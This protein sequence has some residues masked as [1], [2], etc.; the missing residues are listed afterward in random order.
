MGFSTGSSS[1]LAK[2]ENRV[3][4]LQY[5]QSTFGTTKQ[6][7]Y[8]TN[9]ICGN[10]IDNTDFTAIPHI[11]KT[12]TGGKGG[13]GGQTSVSYTYKSRCLIGLCCGQI[14]GV[15][16]VEFDDGIYSLSQL[17]MTLF[18]GSAAQ[19]AWGE[20]LSLH[21]EHSLTY[22]NLA[23]VAGYIDLT[24]SGGVPQ[25][26]FEVAGKC[27]F[28]GL[29]ANP[30]DVAI[31]VLTNKIYG[32]GFPSEYI[33]YSSFEEFSNYCIAN[34]VLLSPVYDA[35]EEVQSLLSDLFSICNST[36]IWTQGKLK[37]IPLCDEKITGHG[38][39]YNP[40]LTPVYDFDEKDFI[41]DDEPVKC[42]R[43]EQND[44]YN[45]VKIEY[46]NRANEY[47][48]EVVEAQDLAN[49][50][51]FGVRAADTQKAHLICRTDI[52]QSVAQLALDRNIAVRNTYTFK[53]PF[54][55]IMLD[56]MDI[57]TIT[58]PL[59]GL[60]REPVRI[61][62]IK[63]SDMQLEIEA[64][65]MVI[66]S[67]N[68]AK[69]DTQEASFVS[70]DS[71]QS[72]GNINPIMIFEPPMQLTHNT[73]EVWV[74]IS[75]NKNLFG[76]CEIYISDD[77]STYRL[78]GKQ[79]QQC[80]QGILKNHLG[81]S[82]KNPDDTN[83][84]VVDMNMSNAELL[85][86]TKEDAE[87]LNTLCYVGGEFLA[88]KAATLEDIGIYNL[89]YLNRGAYGSEVNPHY[90]GDQFTRIDED[91]F[92]KIS[93]NKEDIGKEIFIK[94]PS[95]NSFGAGIQTLGD[96]NP[97]TY[98]IQGAALK[99]APEN[100]T[101]LTNYYSDGLNII[102][103]QP[104][105][106]ARNIVYEIRKGS[107]W[108]KA[109]CLG[110]IAQTTF[111]A[112]GNGTYWVKAYVPDYNIYSVEA[113]SLEITGA[114]LVQNV[115]D[116]TDEQEKGFKGNKSKSMFV[117]DY[118]TL[119]LA[120]AGKF[121]EIEQF[122]KISSVLFFGGITQEGIYECAKVVDIGA[123]SKCYIHVEYNFL[124]ENPFSTFG[125][126]PKLSEVEK[127]IENFGEFITKSRI[128]IAIAQN[129]EF[130]DWQDFV[131]GQYFGRKF[132]FRALLESSSD[133]VVAKLNKL[134]LNIDVPDL[135][136]TGN[137]IQI[138]SDGIRIL[139]KKHFHATPNLQVTI[140]DKSTG[141]DEF[142][143]NLDSEGF[144][145][146]LRNGTEQIAKY[147]NFVAQGY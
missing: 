13:G 26:N 1:S 24:T 27:L 32:A 21:P 76:G 70:V 42:K 56:P 68:P 61:K 78:I 65:E 112:N 46:K 123:A 75:S 60:D 96:V 25:Y 115:I 37:A 106:D 84:L 22:R 11:T 133:S 138:P 12:Q 59:L 92:L 107:T 86:G 146:Q 35:Q 136:E 89:R 23:Y 54:R 110:R 143:T 45:S 135:V 51:L 113:V 129:E 30:R 29:D 17:N 105:D 28:D 43:A 147:I 44:I 104:V 111:T 126:I 121:S 67:A 52:A 83:S 3:N 66:G 109:Q 4:A 71:N 73:L 20:M 15:K 140:L 50:E 69:I 130:S 41:D 55:F 7:V 14:A 125:K 124:G 116:I 47:A 98:K 33:D 142:I 97:Y 81:V 40:D 49:I 99:Q 10:L 85:A 19:N 131:T 134:I 53:V 77:G 100:V 80:R 119:S 91:A 6:V 145:I 72:V 9:N 117:D 118:G 74:G 2:E 127:L 64:E 34:N 58:Y 90:K 8:G 48:T 57:V 38:K 62:S 137:N 63:E 39:T 139:F 122:S 18:N 36:F 5:E 82:E 103:W 31:D 102:K 108:G 141:D 94:C 16:K 128:Q 101:G 114:R 132:K 87:R 79:T 93:F 144:N 120:G 95:F 88:Y